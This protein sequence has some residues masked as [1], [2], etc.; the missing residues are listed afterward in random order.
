MSDDLRADVAG[1]M[2]EL[3]HEF[4]AHEL[5]DEQ[6]A[7]FAE[8]LAALRDIV[9]GSPPRTRAMASSF[10]DFKMAI[11]E[12]GRHVRHQLFADSIVSGNANPMGLGATLWRQGETAFM[13]VSLGKAFEGAPGRSH[14]GIVAALIDET[15]GLVLALHD[16]LAFTGRLD[17][18]YHAPTPIDTPIVARAWLDH[19]D[20]RKLRLV[21]S[22]TAND[23]EVA[24]AKALFI[25]VDPERFLARHALES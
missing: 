11:P 17:I 16:L 23:V 20:G 21:S 3:G 14:G 8:H 19:R 7:R 24:S 15:M 4:V 1:V 13:E 22:V 2:R 5:S 6:F 9:A 25:A 18:S 12:E 10:E